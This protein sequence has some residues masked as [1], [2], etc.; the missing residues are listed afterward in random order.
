M[1]LPWS[2]V[3]GEITSF[4]DAMFTS[5]TSVCVTGLATQVTADHWTLFGKIIILLLIQIGGLGFVSMVSLV[6]ITIRKRIDL[7]SR[8]II[9]ESYNQEHLSGMVTMV[10]RIGKGI[11]IVEALGALC[12]M[13]VWIPEYGLLRGIWYSVFH[14]VSAFCNAGLD[15]FGPSSL[16]EYVD[17]I[18]INLITMGLIIMGGIGFVVWWDLEKNIKKIFR[19]QISVR[20]FWPN[21]ELHSKLVLGMTVL[22]LTSGVILILAFEWSNPRTM[23]SFSPGEKILAAAFQSVTTRTAGFFTIDQAGLRDQSVMVCLMLMFVGGSPMGTAG[24]IK[25]TTIAILILTVNTY[26]RGKKDVEVFHRKLR[27]IQVRGAIAISMISLALLFLALIGLSVLMP[28][29]NFIDI[30]YELTSALGTVG[31]SRGLTPELTVASKWLVI[32][33]MYF[34]RIGPITLVMAMF[35]KS[36][37]RRGNIR[38]AEGKVLIG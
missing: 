25:T 13:T 37:K 28:Q 10:R 1:W 21:L 15:L 24:G 5:A 22:L 14:S 20:S 23:E 31:L 36:D 33:V 38:L 16:G 19:G 34:G 11:L 29:A 4:T 7:R 9:Q 2:T 3:E 12:Y 30:L 26:L 18:P 17:S 27:E 35:L 6:F 8:R 32:C